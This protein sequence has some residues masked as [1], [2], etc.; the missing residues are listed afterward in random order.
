MS[1]W[2]FTGPEI[3]ERD[4]AVQEVCARAQAQGTVDVHR[5]YAH[6]T[7]VA[8]LVD[9]LRTRALFADAVCVVLYNAEVIKKCDE[10]HVLTEWIKDGGSRA[11]VF[12]VLISDS[13]SIHKRIEQNISPVHK[14]VFWELFENKKHAWV[15]R[16]FF[17]HEM[18]IEQEAIESLLELVE[19]NTRALKTVCTQLSLFFEKGRR[20]TA[21]DIS[22][23]LVHTKEETSFTLFDALSKR[24]L[25][26][27][28]MILN[29][30]LCSKDVAP[31]QILAGL[32]YA[33]RRLAH[34]HHIPEDKTHPATLKRYGFTSRRMIAQYQRAASLWTLSDTHA[35]LDRLFQTDAMIRSGGTP[36]QGP[37]MQLCLYAIVVHAGDRK[38]VV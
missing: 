32:A 10:V 35:I 34:W 23:L 21:H 7:P 28:L 13:V 12:L 15:Q 20:I 22:S 18:R 37:L 26:H 8:D 1:V 9:L 29:T 3:G 30:L 38:S 19:N 24:D 6:E 31:V 14:R 27:S 17:Q 36:L 5:L 16:F 25:E 11:D 33:F 2:L 4:S